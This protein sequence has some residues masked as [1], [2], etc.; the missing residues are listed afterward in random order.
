VHADDRSSAIRLMSE[1]LAAF[2]ISGVTT[3]IPFH[4]KVLAHEDFRS[5]AIHTRWVDQEFMPA[6]PAPAA[7]AQASLVQAAAE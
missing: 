7:L 5:A 2:D 1:A 4:R 3:T 6:M